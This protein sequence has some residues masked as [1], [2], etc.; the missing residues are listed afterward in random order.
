[1]ARSHIAGAM[2]DATDV[3]AVAHKRATWPH[4]DI[5]EWAE[6]YNGLA[7]VHRATQAWTISVSHRWYA[8]VAA[9]NAPP[10]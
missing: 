2:L 6:G 3:G 5:V 9:E 1:M 4:I 7:L 8:G 10:D